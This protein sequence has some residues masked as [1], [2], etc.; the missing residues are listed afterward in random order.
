[1]CWPFAF[2]EHLAIKNDALPRRGALMSGDENASGKRTDLSHINTFGC[3]MWV[4]H[5]RAKSKK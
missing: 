5:T 3:H 2:N 1:M 4:K